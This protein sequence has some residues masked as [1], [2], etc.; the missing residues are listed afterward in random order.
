MTGSTAQSKLRAR[1]IPAILAVALG[2]FA[3]LP[4]CDLHFDCGCTWPGAGS[5]S[6]CDIHTS[7]PPDCPWCDHAWIG[8]LA[9]GFGAVIGLAVVWVLPHRTPGVIVTLSGIAACLLGILAAGVVTS[10]WLELPLFAGL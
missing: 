6:H 4:I 8:Y 1:V 10:L 5:D 7:G 2:A 3:F 9:M